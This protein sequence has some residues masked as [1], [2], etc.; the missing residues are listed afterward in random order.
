MVRVGGTGGGVAPPAP[1]AVQD[2]SAA[3]VVRP[4][5]T[6]VASAETSPTIVR[7]GAFGQTVPRTSASRDPANRDPEAEAVFA[8]RRAQ[9]LHEWRQ[10]AQGTRAAEGTAVT[11]LRGNTGG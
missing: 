3:R 9:V 5:G 1:R 8:Q 6:L 11:I 4:A 10:S 2:L 7:A